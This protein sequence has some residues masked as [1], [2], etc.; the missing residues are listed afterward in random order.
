[1]KNDVHGINATR[2]C[3]GDGGGGYLDGMRGLEQ[4]SFAGYLCDDAF[5]LMQKWIDKRRKFLEFGMSQ[6]LSNYRGAQSYETRGT[7][8]ADDIINGVYPSLVAE[9][10]PSTAAQSPCTGHEGSVQNTPGAHAPAQRSVCLRGSR[11]HHLPTA[12]SL[13]GARVHC[14]SCR[15][16]AV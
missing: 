3:R 9:C 4:A 2:G 1:M 6:A 5:A 16:P 8:I 14:L 11:S 7:A 12:R 13:C 10:V 15:C